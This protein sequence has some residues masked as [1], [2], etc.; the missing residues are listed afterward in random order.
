MGL[1]LTLLVAPSAY[2]GLIPE[3]IVLN[4]GSHQ[5][6][7]NTVYG[8]QQDRIQYKYHV[9][10]VLVKAG[11]IDSGQYSDTAP[12]AIL[13]N[14]T[15]LLVWSSIPSAEARSE[16]YFSRWLSG[17]WS[18]AD[19]AHASNDY[20]DMSPTLQPLQDGGA[21]LYW[22]QNTGTDVVL[23]WASFSAKGLLNPVAASAL[24]SPPTPT[25][26][27]SAASQ[28]FYA[29]MNARDPDGPMNCIAFG[30]SITQGQKRNAAGVTSGVT[31]PPNGGQYGAYVEELKALLQVDISTVNVYNYGVNGERSYDGVARINSVMAS[32]S[33]SNCILIMYGANDRYQGLHP[34]S[35]AA[36][37]QTMAERA[38][39]A[40][41]IPIVS[42]IT[43]NT[44][45]GGITP[46]NSAILTM[47]DN[48]GIDVADQYTALNANWAVYNT[49]DGLHISHAG[50]AIMA[51]VWEQVMRGNSKLFSN[52][53]AAH[54][55]A[56]LLLLLD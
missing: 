12:T 33:A 45:L 11:L 13:L 36:N 15:P 2:A 56:I 14:D 52:N 23:R 55:G 44:A 16:I 30:D 10:S 8:H 31:S 40:G 21:T 5:W 34:S 54:L 22:Y 17:N 48:L 7:L 6:T 18:S 20:A 27:A 51:E 25:A 43:P 47:T 19:K 28:D 38:R 1:A 3:A 41:R 49:G 35:T 32:Q 29:S 53:V 24:F 4:S 42:T 39:L 46:Y 50:D 9:D 26:P 37:I